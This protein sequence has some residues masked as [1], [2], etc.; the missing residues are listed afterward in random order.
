MK[1]LTAA[2]A[3]RQFSAVLKGVSGGESYR[4]TSHGKPVAVIAPIA[5][6]NCERRAARDALLKRLETQPGSGERAWTRAE[7]YD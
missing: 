3:N 5:T 1:T 4:V 7:L 6:D 2:E